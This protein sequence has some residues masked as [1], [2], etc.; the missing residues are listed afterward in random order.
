MTEHLVLGEDN[1][2]PPANLRQ[3]VLVLGLGCEMVLMDFNGETFS[4]ESPGEN[5]IAK[6][7]VEKKG[8]EATRLLLGARARSGWLLQCRT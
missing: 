2:L 1:P 6:A 3:P 5:S 4:A 8:G 7:A